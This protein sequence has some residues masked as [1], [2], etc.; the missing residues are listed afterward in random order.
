MQE[1]S[2]TGAPIWQ[3][4]EHGTLNDDLGYLG[5]IRSPA[6]SGER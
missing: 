6:A 3:T 1:A 4:D 5:A 2:V